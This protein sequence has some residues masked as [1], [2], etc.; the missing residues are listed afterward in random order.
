M[1][2]YN[3][4]GGHNKIVPGAA[5]FLNEVTEDRKVKNA[6]IE[7]LD[8]AGHT[9]YDCTDDAGRT[10]GANLANIV[11]KCNKHTVDRDISIHL[12]S[13]RKDSKGD[14]KTGGVEAFIYDTDLKD[15]AKAVADAIAD[16]FGYALRS[17]GT[18]PSGCAG[19]KISKGLYVLRNTKAPAM[20]IE[21]CFVDDKDD[22]KVWNAERCAR[23]IYKGLTGKT[24][25]SGNSVGSKPSGGS[26]PTT[27]TKSYKV[28]INTTSGVNVR[29]GAG[30]KYGIITAIPNGK[31]VTISKTSGSWGYT[32]FNG[33]KGWIC[34]DYTKKVASG[35]SSSSSCSSKPSY[36]TGS[37]Y[38]VNVDALTV[39]TGAGTN[40]K[41]KTKSQLTADG[42]KHANGNGCLVKGTRVTCQATKSVGSDIWMKIPSGW[43]AAYYSGKKYVK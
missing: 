21:C 16:E 25:S 31:T 26:K 3:I 29:S 34:L 30:K 13:G 2:R 4:H 40:Y 14:G 18:T 8:D 28:K 37:T 9:V 11:A 19:V 41:A 7:L 43:I 12:N 36:K 23:A 35:S 24:A 39:R 27:S 33:K 22:A 38:T 17:D 42:Q 32:S 6:L 20:L 1:G 5:K 15:V 10:S